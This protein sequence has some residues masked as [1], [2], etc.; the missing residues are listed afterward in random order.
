MTDLDD[1][2]ELVRLDHGLCV[3]TTLRAD[4]SVQASVVNSGVLHHPVTGAS[5]VGLV[6]A[7]GSLKLRHLRADPRATV[8]SRAGW[9]WATVEGVAEIVGPDD[10]QP[11]IDAEALRR[12]LQDVFQAAGGS[13]DDWDAFDRVM[14]DERRAAVLISPNRAYT[15]PTG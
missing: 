1:F 10:S 6:A 5:V 7:G 14:R 4:G 8:I 2:A 11:D 13:H 12:L 15:N 3:L 9:R